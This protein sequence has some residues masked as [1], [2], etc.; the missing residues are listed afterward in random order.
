MLKNRAF[1]RLFQ[2]FAH[3]SSVF[4]HQAAGFDLLLKYL[5]HYLVYFLLTFTCQLPTAQLSCIAKW[6]VLT[7]MMSS[8][9][10]CTFLYQSKILTVYNFFVTLCVFFS[11]LPS[12][13]LTLLA[14][15][16]EE[17]LACKK[18]EWNGPGVV[19]CLEWGAIDLYMIQLMPMLP[20]QLLLC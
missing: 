17:L 6:I 1:K 13:L 7:R 5:E 15:H 20:H 18:I 4:H 3:L 2:L 11:C 10:V 14:G 16:Q 12:V 9:S 8:F 19:V